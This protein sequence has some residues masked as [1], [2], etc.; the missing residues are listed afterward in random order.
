MMIK[1]NSDRIVKAAAIAALCCSAVL[2]QAQSPAAPPASPEAVAS[3]ET[4]VPP[5]SSDPAWDEALDGAGSAGVE[6]PGA[7][8]KYEAVAKR[9]GTELSAQALASAPYISDAAVGHGKIEVPKG[10]AAYQ[11]FDRVLVKPVGK[12]EL[13][14]KAGDTVDVISSRA[15]AKFNGVSVRVVSRKGRAV[16]EEFVGSKAVI[17]LIEMWGVV[18]GGESIAATTRFYPIYCDDLAAPP[19]QINASVA[20]R[21]GETVTPYLHQYFIIDKGSADGVMLGD[22]F[23]VKE[24]KPSGQLSEEVLEAQVVSVSPSSATLVI[25]KLAKNSLKAGDHAFLSRRPVIR[26]AAQ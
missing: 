6:A 14:F 22:F 15:R 3:P 17:R 24:K 13:E 2:A 23:K 20:I 11:Q 8:A 21:I 5:P 25:Q 12:A 9:R 7:A 16:V 18:E 1:I 26:P 10:R 19:T 4:A